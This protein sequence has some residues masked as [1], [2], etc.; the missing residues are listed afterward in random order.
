M[1]S[2]F[3][4]KDLNIIIYL[5][6]AEKEGYLLKLWLLD[7]ILEVCHHIHVCGCMCLCVCM[8]MFIFYSCILKMPP[9]LSHLKMF[10]LLLFFLDFFNADHFES[11]YRICYN[12]ASVFCV[13]DILAVRSVGSQLPDQG[14]NP[15][16]AAP[17]PPAPPALEGRVT[18]LGLPGK[19]LSALL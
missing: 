1:L 2:S 15:T 12:I 5:L 18:T 11:L 3:P 17:R 6:E 13:L 9:M 7:F 19:S 4:R 14:S 10:V 16:T 8:S